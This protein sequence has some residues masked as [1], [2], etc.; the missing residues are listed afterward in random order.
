MQLLFY[1]I[2]LKRTYLLFFAMLVF[3]PLFFPRKCFNVFRFRSSITCSS[4]SSDSTRLL[5]LC[6]SCGFCK[7]YAFWIFSF[8]SLRSPTRFILAVLLWSSN[9]YPVL[10][11]PFS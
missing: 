9:V 3:L 2:H 5:Q 7:W 6:H 4:F 11:N 10:L 1:L 8:A